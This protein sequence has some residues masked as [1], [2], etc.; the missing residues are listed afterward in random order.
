MQR[1]IR[2]LLIAS[3]FF[4]K[5]EERGSPAGLTF[6]IIFN[7]RYRVVGSF[8]YQGS[9]SGIE[10]NEDRVLTAAGILFYLFYLGI[11]RIDRR[12]GRCGDGGGR[13][14]DDYPNGS[15]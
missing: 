4:Q 12:F 14:A 15:G 8:F 11:G 13:A 7:N 1:K 10:G 9:Y 2:F 6:A 5:G 3:I